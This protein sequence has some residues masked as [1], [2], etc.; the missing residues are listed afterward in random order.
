MNG[1]FFPITCR[2][3]DG[4]LTATLYGGYIGPSWCIYCEVTYCE[5]LENVT[6][7]LTR[8]DRPNLVAVNNLDEHGEC[9]FEGILPGH[10]RLEITLSSA[11]SWT[12]DVTIPTR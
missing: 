2:F 6:V 4:R 10:Y 12:Q 5:R 3:L 1:Q 7:S 11:S 9:E 8:I